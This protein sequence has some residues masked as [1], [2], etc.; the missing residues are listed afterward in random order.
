MK[1]ETFTYR[2]S[3]QY[4]VFPG[5]HQGTVAGAGMLFKH[6]RG[7][8]SAADIRHIDLKAS[9]LNP[10]SQFQIKAFQQL[11]RLDVYL[12]ADLSASM[13]YQGK[14]NKKQAV[15]DCLLS[16]AA[17][18]HAIGD[19]FGFVGCGKTIDSQ[20]LI[21]PASLQFGRVVEM[22]K[23]LRLIQLEGRAESLLQSA[24]F[25]PEKPGLV[26]LISDFYLPDTII[27]HLLQ[28]LH[29]HVVVPLVIWDEQ[30]MSDLPAWGIVKF[31]DMEQRK[32][33]TLF[34]RPALREKIKSAFLQRRRSLT[35]TFRRFGN[36]PVFF[37]QG[38]HAELLERYFLQFTE[39]NDAA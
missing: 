15:V 24:D 8:N 33:R 36:E 35:R 23:K 10:F 39:L 6:H 9:V 34:M 16:V 28:R 3:A 31:A 12:I 1:Y 37:E 14:Y 2:K 13:A 4:S 7:L 38:Y 5:A 19:R 32:S 22:V 26:F 18:A 21:S 11:S 25:L 20:T 17:S 29:H 27:I 30:E